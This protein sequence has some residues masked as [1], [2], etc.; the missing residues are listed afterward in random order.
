MPNAIGK[1]VV[2]RRRNVK[3]LDT[4]LLQFGDGFHDVLRRHGDVLDAFAIIKFKI[5]FHLRFLFAFGRFVDRKLHETVAVAHHLAHQRRV[6]GR[7]VLVVKGKDVSKSHHILVKLHPRIHL[8]PADVSDAMIDILQTG[9]RRIVGRLPFSKPRHER[10]AIIFSLD[11]QM[12]HVSV[13]VN[14]AHHQLA[15]IIRQRLRLH[16][17]FT[18]ALGRFFPGGS[19]VFHRQC[20]CLHSIA[21][22]VNVIGNRVIRSNRSR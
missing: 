12:N 3:E 2:V 7:D 11:E 9:L 10:P 4:A 15:V 21:M 18:A 14:P 19:C 17:T 20:E 6:F 16:E 22:F 5:L 1:R 8:V 13:C